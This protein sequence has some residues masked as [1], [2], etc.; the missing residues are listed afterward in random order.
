[1]PAYKFV[2]DIVRTRNVR[3]NILPPEHLLSDSAPNLRPLISRW[4]IDKVEDC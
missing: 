4:E 3:N 1:M 2:M